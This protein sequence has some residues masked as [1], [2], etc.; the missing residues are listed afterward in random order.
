MKLSVVIPCYNELNSI[1]KIIGVVKNSPYPKKEIIIVDDCSTDGTKVK[2][3]NEI[4]KVID[5]I[6]H[7]HENPSGRPL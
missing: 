1:E 6:K 5:W 4:E 2:L 3:E 7:N